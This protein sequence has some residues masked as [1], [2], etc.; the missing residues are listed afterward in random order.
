MSSQSR[1]IIAGLDARGGKIALRGWVDQT[2][3]DAVTLAMEYAEIPYD[4]VWGDDVLKGKL[5]QYDWIHLHHDVF[6][7]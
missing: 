5:L 7:V 4:K 3:T 2:A 1:R 6:D